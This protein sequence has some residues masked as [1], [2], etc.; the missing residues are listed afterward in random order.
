MQGDCEMR[1]V[2]GSLCDFPLP[3]P[4][5]RERMGQGSNF[6]MGWREWGHTFSPTR[7]KKNPLSLAQEGEPLFEHSGKEVSSLNS[8]SH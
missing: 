4:C 8:R 2:F 5:D 6:P 1:W 3:Q 7:C